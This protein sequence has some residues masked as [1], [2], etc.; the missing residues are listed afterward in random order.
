VILPADDQT[1]KVMQPSKQ[2]LDLPTAAVAA[3]LAAVLGVRLAAIMLMRSNPL[4]ALLLQFVIQRIAVVGAV[5]DQPLRRCRR[6]TLLEG[7]FDEP[8][9]MRRSACNPH[10]NRKT[11]AVRN[12]HD[13][14][15]FAAACWTNSTAPFLAL[16]KEASINVSARSKPP[17]AIKSWARAR[18]NSTSTPARTHCR[19]RR[20]QVWYGGNLLGISAHWAPVRR[21]Q[22]TPS[23]TARVS[24][25][26]RP[27]RLAGVLGSTIDFSNSH[28]T[29]VS[30]MLTGVPVNS[31]SHNYL[32]RYVFMR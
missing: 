27:R 18:N 30:S 11:M 5:T 8:S 13:L 7:G 12:C 10:G 23:S 21:I 24:F 16:V 22:S 19:K 26:G 4:D 1:A 3:Q 25:H 28:C 15:P 6:E 32:V 14:G 17:R 2:T 31:T 29:S 20:W 9:F